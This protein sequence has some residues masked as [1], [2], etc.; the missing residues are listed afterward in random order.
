ML[1]AAVATQFKGLILR[2]ME[3]Q[4]TA[5]WAFD[6]AEGVMTKEAVKAR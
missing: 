1:T 4:S 5:V 3:Q 6:W 2:T